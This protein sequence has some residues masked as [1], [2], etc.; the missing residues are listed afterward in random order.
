MKLY[1]KCY[2]PTEDVV[3]KRRYRNPTEKIKTFDHDAKSLKHK[4]V[5]NLCIISV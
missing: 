2:L 5:H 3:P 1:S 4:K